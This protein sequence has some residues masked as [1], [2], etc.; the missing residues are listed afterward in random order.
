MFDFICS[1]ALIVGYFG[2]LLGLDVL[3]IESGDDMTKHEKMCEEC[4]DPHCCCK[5]CK[6]IV[7]VSDCRGKCDYDENKAVCVSFGE[8]KK[9]GIY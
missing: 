6:G 8:W 5:D 4:A 1:S 7:I 2:F 9:E 3:M